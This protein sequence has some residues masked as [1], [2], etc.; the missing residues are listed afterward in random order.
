LAREL[1]TMSVATVGRTSEAEDHEMMIP[2]ILVALVVIMR[3][4]QE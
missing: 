1:G 4:A 2:L 3:A